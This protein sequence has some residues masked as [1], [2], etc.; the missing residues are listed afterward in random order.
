MLL[1]KSSAWHTYTWSW[2][3]FGSR[4]RQA[5]LYRLYGT[6]LGYHTGHSSKWPLRCEVSWLHHIE[7]HQR[8]FTCRLASCHGEMRNPILAIESD[9]YR[10]YLRL[11]IVEWCLWRANWTWSVDVRTVALQSRSGRRRW[12]RQLRCGFYHYKWWGIVFGRG[13]A[14]GRCPYTLALSLVGL[15]SPH[16]VHRK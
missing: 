11:G 4:S 10:V 9:H 3:W 13:L 1:A 6:H 7:C 14:K 16:I 12:D 15:W 2:L 5:L 8:S